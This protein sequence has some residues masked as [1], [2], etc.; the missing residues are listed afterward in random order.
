MPQAAGLREGP[1]ETLLLDEA[2][3]RFVRGCAAVFVKITVLL[4]GYLTRVLGAVTL[5]VT[6]VGQ[7]IKI[8][9]ALSACLP[10]PT[11]RKESDQELV[12]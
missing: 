3:I 7:F 6:R 8:D 2:F 1:C 10:Y 4:D 11:I 5:W 12:V 9:R